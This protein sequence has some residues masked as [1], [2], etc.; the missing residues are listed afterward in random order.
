MQE[1][2]MAQSLRRFVHGLILFKKNL[3]LWAKI[4]LGR[5]PDRTSILASHHRSSYMS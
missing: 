3:Q 1:V 2:F 5:I 4:C